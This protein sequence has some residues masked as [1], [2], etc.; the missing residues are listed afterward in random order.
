MWFFFIKIVVS[1]YCFL[2]GQQNCFFISN[3]IHW[4]KNSSNKKK[5]TIP[6]IY[7]F[8]IKKE[9]EREYIKKNLNFLIQV[10]LLLLMKMLFYN[11]Y[12]FFMEKY[13]YNFESKLDLKKKS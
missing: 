13:H 6:K 10:F 4:I 12:C 3:T 2:F 11:E 9:E 5:K 1:M 8:E 7:R